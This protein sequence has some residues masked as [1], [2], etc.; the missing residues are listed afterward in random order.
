MIRTASTMA[1]LMSIFILS[2]ERADS[3]PTSTPQQSI[4]SSTATNSAYSPDEDVS[5]LGS[6]NE[7]EKGGAEQR[8]EAAGPSAISSLIKGLDSANAETK[9]RAMNILRAIVIKTKSLINDPIAIELGKKCRLEKDERI[10]LQIV[11]TLRTLPG[12]AST[13]ELEWI[14]HNDPNE[15]ARRSATHFVA[16]TSLNKEQN[17]TFFRSQTSDKSIAVQLAAYIQLAELGDASGRN[18]GL[19][20]LN[21]SYADLYKREAVDLIGTIANPADLALLKSFTA[22]NTL[23]AS[24]AMKASMRLELRQLPM[25]QRLGSLLKSLD[26]QNPDVRY[27]AYAELYHSVDPNT[28][29]ALRKYLGEKGHIG[30]KEAGDALSVR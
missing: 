3:A 9:Y 10:R 6:L 26:N 27:W 21:G 5:A 7:V 19:S 25:S 18:L 1:F 4:A 24:P 2:A 22:T 20:I 29:A 11:S 16:D 30:Y 28:D 12:Q 14:A 15:W 23:I 17:R 13:R 8:L